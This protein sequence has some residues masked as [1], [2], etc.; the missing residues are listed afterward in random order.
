MLQA[1]SWQL[2]M[3]RQSTRRACLQP[4]SL[5]SCA[6]GMHAWRHILTWLPAHESSQLS[7]EQACAPFR[8]IG[9]EHICQHSQ[10][11]AAAAD[12]ACNRTE[13]IRRVSSAPDRRRP[14]QHRVRRG[15]SSRRRRQ[16]QVRTG[17]PCSWDEAWQGR[18]RLLRLLRLRICRL[19]AARARRLRCWLSCWLSCGLRGLGH[20]R[21]L[22]WLWGCCQRGLLWPGTPD[23]EAVGSHLHVH[24]A[25]RGLWAAVRG[26]S[27]A[28]WHA[29]RG[30]VLSG[31]QALLTFQVSCS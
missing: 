4:G 11:P 26:A 25:F 30:A 6:A 15:P 29:H 23:Q 3:R 14:W 8:A 17:L 20:R 16:R 13:Q 24:L 18:S 7:M 21:R 5:C 12:S 2:D 9:C 1:G 19:A 28:W 27:P 31:R 22:G 10:K